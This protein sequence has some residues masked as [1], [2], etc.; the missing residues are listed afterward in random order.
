M[1][2]CNGCQQGMGCDGLGELPLAQIDALENYVVAG[3][4]IEWGGKVYWPES[5]DSIGWHSDG[6]A[7]I[8]NA[9]W[10]HGGFSMVN[11]G[12]IG[13][14]WNPYISIVVTTK[15]DFAKLGDVLVTIEGAVYQAG[16]KPDSQNFWVKS[17][18]LVAQN[19]TG[20]A[21]PNAGAG[22]PK[23]PGWQLPNIFGGSTDPSNNGNPID[24]L[25][26]WLGVGQTEAALIGAGA[27]LAGILIIKKLL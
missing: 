6:E 11:A 26:S 12:N 16:Y 19:R 7:R 14:R 18:P 3:S 25:A 1:S 21:Q 2:C 15:V 4:V 27:A 20:V 23:S 17:V 5:E 8:K 10:S 24:S 9:L 13:S 22:Q